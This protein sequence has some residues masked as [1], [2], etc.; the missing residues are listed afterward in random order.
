MLCKNENENKG[1]GSSLYF[2]VAH[3][4]SVSIRGNN[5][6]WGV[7]KVRSPFALVPTTHTRVSLCADAWDSGIL[8]LEVYFS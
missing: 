7:K 5:S 8:Q 1:I 2:L 6:I 4:S 3:T